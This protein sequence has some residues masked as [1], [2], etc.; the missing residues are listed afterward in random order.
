M[1]SGGGMPALMALQQVERAAKLQDLEV[2]ADLDWRV[3]KCEW[4]CST[5][6]Q[7]G[8]ILQACARVGQ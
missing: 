1:T 4:E 7:L 8:S 3:R 2:W 5:D 6:S